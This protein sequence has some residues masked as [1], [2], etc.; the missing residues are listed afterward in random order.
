MMSQVYLTSR[1][2]AY[3]LPI[4]TGESL[5]VRGRALSYNRMVAEASS[6]RFLKAKHLGFGWAF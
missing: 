6:V 3:Q 5:R 4:D 2:Y 1:A